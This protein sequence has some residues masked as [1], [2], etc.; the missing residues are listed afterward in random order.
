MTIGGIGKTALDLVKI[1]MNMCGSPLDSWLREIPL[2]MY[3]PSL[4]GTMTMVGIGKTAIL[5]FMV[6]RNPL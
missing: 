3:S 2:E 4:M 6:R 5:G 1:H